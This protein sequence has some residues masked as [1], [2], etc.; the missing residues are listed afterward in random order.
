MQRHF[1]ARLDRFVERR[2]QFQAL[3]ALQTIDQRT[4]LM[5]QAIDYIL[6]IGLV[7]KAIDV[8]RVDRKLLYHILVRWQ[9]VDE[10]PVPDLVD[11]EAGDLDRALLAEDRQRA[12]EIGRP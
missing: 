9:F 12:F 4:A 2:D 7:P 1:L 3:A 6:I 11:G 8:G 5:H 10:P